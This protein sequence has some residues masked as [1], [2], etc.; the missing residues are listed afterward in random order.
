ML[1]ISPAFAPCAL[2]G[3]ARMTSLAAYLAKGSYCV[4]VIS[5]GK[6]YFKN[7]LWCR[8]VPKDI[9]LIEIS[10][11]SKLEKSLKSEIIL[12]L[13]KCRYD[14]CITSMGPYETQKF[15]WKLCNRYDVPLILDYRDP[16][17]FYKYYYSGRSILV[18][19][20]RFL[21]DMFLLRYEYKS[22]S[23]ASNVVTVSKKNTEILQKRYRKSA[24]KMTTIF[25]G[26]E[27]IE[28]LENN[29]CE[30]RE[31]YVIGCAGKFIY[32]NESAALELVKAV[33]ELNEEGIGISI[34]HIG[35]EMDNA[36]E[37]L[38][39]K[40]I[41]HSF[42]KYV[43]KLGY[44]DTM[45]RLSNMDAVLIIYG[46]RE[47]LGTKVFDYIGVN[48]PIIYCGI[49]PSEL[50]DFV[51]DFKNVIVTD[52]KTALKKGLTDFVKRNV[53]T[54]ENTPCKLYS[55]ATQNRKYEVIIKSAIKNDTL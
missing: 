51:S 2:V 6:W 18:K 21:L 16:W 31:E 48:K 27:C 35:E 36:T 38:K 23:Y 14:I 46:F 15:L 54:L 45:H 7:D 39:S 26:H 20:K 37:L 32:Y 49:L 42:Y 55:R 17:L 29:Q 4:S 41:D 47:G 1:I 50:G 10:E 33:N 5:I 52:N 3:A 28:K 13:S 40:G 12:C 8:Q 19:T 53:Q 24:H 11:T 22:I 34:V 43:G 30:K 25:N 44:D 9:S